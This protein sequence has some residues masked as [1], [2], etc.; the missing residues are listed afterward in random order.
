ML[1]VY[2][3]TY[4]CMYTFLRTHVRMFMYIFLSTN[5]TDNF[6]NIPIYEIFKSNYTF[7]SI[8][9]YFPNCFVENDL[10]KI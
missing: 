1:C 6:Y 7:S 8:I 3:F 10:Q 5:F 2:M 4:L 9:I